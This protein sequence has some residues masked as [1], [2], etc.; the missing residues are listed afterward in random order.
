MSA[1]SFTG[2]I[3]VNSFIEVQVHAKQ[4]RAVLQRAVQRF[5]VCS[6]LCA[7]IAAV[8]SGTLAL[9][10]TE[11]LGPLAVTSA[12]GLSPTETYLCSLACS[13]HSAQ[14]CELVGRLLCHT[15]C[16]RVRVCSLAVFLLWSNSALPYLAYPSVSYWTRAAATLAAVAAAP[17]NVHAHVFVWTPLRFSWAHTYEDVLGQMGTLCFTCSGQAGRFPRA[18]APSSVPGARVSGLPLPA[19]THCALFL[20]SSCVG[21]AASSALVCIFLMSSHGEHVFNVLISHL[22]VFFDNV[23]VSSLN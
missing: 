3:F 8:N 20:P 17:V 12:Q 19:S 15:G 13:G 5:V 18:A 11:T 2:S 23:F 7:A 16:L 6:Q 9:P 4:L 21:R 22:C 10:P 1:H 14:C